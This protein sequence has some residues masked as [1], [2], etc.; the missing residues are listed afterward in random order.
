MN[1]LPTGRP[2]PS[3]KADRSIV[4][5]VTLTTAGRTRSIGRTTGSFV[6]STEDPTAAGEIAAPLPDDRPGAGRERERERGDRDEQTLHRVPPCDPSGRRAH[7][8]PAGTGAGSCAPSQASRR[9]PVPT[10]SGRGRR[11]A[12][13]RT[14]WI[15]PHGGSPSGGRPGHLRDRGP[16]GRSPPR[17]ARRRRAGAPAERRPTGR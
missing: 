1:P 3:P 10:G 16:P 4:S 7:R 17:S 5:V 11:S 15:P 6:T 9:R 2:P 14:R 12:S 8:S 13:S